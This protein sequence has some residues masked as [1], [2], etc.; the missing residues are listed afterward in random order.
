MTVRV[1]MLEFARYD[2]DQFLI[3]CVRHLFA[4]HDVDQ[5]LID[6]VEDHFYK[7]VWLYLCHVYVMY[8]MGF[9]LW[10]NYKCQSY[11]LDI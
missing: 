6:Y 8:Y 9:S 10:N 2:I 3:N 7:R 1:L 11:N 4:Q 5:F